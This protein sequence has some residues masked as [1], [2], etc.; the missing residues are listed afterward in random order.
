MSTQLSEDG[1]KGI[2]HEDQPVDIRISIIPMVE[3]EKIVMRLLVSALSIIFVC[4]F[5]E[6]NETAIAKITAALHRSYGM[7]LSTGPTGSGKTTSI[8]AMLQILNISRKN[9]TTIEDPV[10]YQKERRQSNTS[11]Y[12]D[13]FDVC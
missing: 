3:G 11:K 7:I 2:I 5:W 8:Y 1:K 13:K 10:E 9:I 12:K 6:W 4:T